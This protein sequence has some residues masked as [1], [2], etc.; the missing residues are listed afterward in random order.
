MGSM[1]EKAIVRS[2]E[3]LKKRDLKAAK[4]II[5]DDLKINQK[6]YEIE[7]SCT[8]LLATQQPMA[9]DLRII[10]AV[11]NIIT[12]LERI[13]DHAE[14]ISKITLMLGDEPPI[15]PLV[16]VPRMGE[17][18]RD[19]LRRTLNAFIDHDTEVAEQICTEDDD[20]DNLY[21]Q[22]YRELLLIM[23]QD[24]RTISRAT[25]LLW[26]GHNLE[27][28]ADR[29]TNICER[30]VFMVNGRIGEMNVSKY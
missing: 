3:A 15:K 29:V 20:I 22:I 12:E 6:R 4:Q 25:H 10:I 16:D 14:G 8:E 19:M 17:K 7:G 28:M 11:L 27:R 5:A 26:V 2:I 21:D 18:I 24:P 1:V 13:A 23:L 30:I 9:K